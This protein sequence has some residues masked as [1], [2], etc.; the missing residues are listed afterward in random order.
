MGRDGLWGVLDGAG[1]AQHPRR[2]AARGV[3]DWKMNER[4][5]NPAKEGPKL[6]SSYPKYYCNV[7]SIAVTYARVWRCYVC[8]VSITS[9]SFLHLHP[10]HTQ[11]FSGILKCKKIFGKDK[12]LGNLPKLL[13][14]LDAFLSQKQAPCTMWG[15]GSL[16]M[17]VVWKEKHQRNQTSVDWSWDLRP[18]MT[19]QQGWL[20]I[21][22]VIPSQYPL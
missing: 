10:P 4:M 3:E 12:L 16:W 21:S 18:G 11:C 17:C 15:H 5:T 6:S 20:R 19:L 8:L 9:Y 14:L 13:R 1:T 22:Q 2:R 7:A